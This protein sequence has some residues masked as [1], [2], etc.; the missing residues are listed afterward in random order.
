MQ[1]IDK[2]NEP[3][4]MKLLWHKN[5]FTKYKKK[6]IKKRPTNLEKKKKIKK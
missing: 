6:E 4:K 3:A 1:N 5:N 2:I